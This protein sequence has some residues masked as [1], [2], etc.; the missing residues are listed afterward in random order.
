MNTFAVGWIMMSS[1]ILFLNSSP[2]IAQK[3]EVRPDSGG[4][5]VSWQDLR[6]QL[7]H[8]N[9]TAETEV[10]LNS[11]YA[12]REFSCDSAAT[13]K[14][15]FLAAAPD[16]AGF[17]AS[18]HNIAIHP[19]GKIRLESAGFSS[20]K[21]DGY[22][23]SDFA[24]YVAVRYAGTRRGVP[25]MEIVAQL[26]YYNTATGELALVESGTIN[27]RFGKEISDE[28]QNKIEKQF[29]A[30][31]VNPS[32]IISKIAMAYSKGKNNTL[33]PDDDWYNPAKT[34]LQI[35]TTRDGAAM[36][37]GNDIIA[38][39]PDWRGKPTAYLELL[40]KGRPYPIAA[41]DYDGVISAADTFYFAGRR[42]AGDTTF[43]D[44]VTDKEPFFLMLG[45]K[46]S[47]AR[48]QPMP[49]VTA[50]ETL[51]TVNIALH[52]EEDHDFNWGVLVGTPGSSS[53]DS[54]NFSY[55]KGF[56]WKMLLTDH[57]NNTLRANA[58][59]LPA[60]DESMSVST[61][62]YTYTTAPAEYR[63]RLAVNG[64]SLAAQQPGNYDYYRY[65]A[66]VPA[67]MF[68]PGNNSLMFINQNVKSSENP[69]LGIDYFT[70]SGKARPF[71]VRGNANF[72][73]P[74]RSASAR[75]SVPGFSAGKI[76]AIDTLTGKYTLTY[77]TAGSFLAAGAAVAGDCS[78]TANDTSTATTGTGLLIAAAYPDGSKTARFFDIKSDSAANFLN[79]LPDGAG[80]AAAYR[81]TE[82]LPAKVRE[83]F[84]KQGAK[85]DIPISWAWACI[86]RKNIAGSLKEQVS[87]TIARADNF[88]EHTGGAS[89]QAS[90][91]LPAADETPLMLADTTAIESVEL[92]LLSPSTLRSKPTDADV[93][94]VAHPNFMQAANRLAAYRRTQGYTVTTAAT[95]DIYKEFSY[96]KKTPEA[97]KSYMRFLSDNRGKPPAYLILFGDA[98]W[99]PL[100]LLP[101]SNQTDYVPTHGFPVSDFWFG[102]LTDNKQYD[103]IVGRLPVHSPEDAQGVVDKLIEYDTL[104]A[105]PWMRNFFFL[106]G[107]DGYSQQNEFYNVFDYAR[108]TL[109][110]TPVCIDTTR[111]RRNPGGGVEQL[112]AIEVRNQVNAGAAWMNFWG[113]GAPEIFDVDGWQVNTLTNRSKYNVLATFSCQ[114]GAFANPFSECRNEGY[115]IA[116]GKGSIAAF[117]N[118][119]TG[120]VDIDKFVNYNMFASVRQ[121]MRRFGDILYAA[122]GGLGF[123]PDYR[124][125]QQQL[126]LIGDPLAR[127]IF[128]SIPD[129]YILDDD[130]RIESPDGSPLVSESDSLTYI[131]A[132]VRN[133]GTHLDSVAIRLI[134]RYNGQSDTLYAS[135]YDVCSSVPA[136]FILKTENKPG[137]HDLSLEINFDNSVMEG[138]RGRNFYQTSFDVLTG[139]AQ[140][141]DPLPLWNVAASKPVFRFVRS[142]NAAPLKYECEIWNDDLTINIASDA[143]SETKGDIT[144]HEAYLEWKPSK[145]ILN[146]GS[147]YIV[148][149]RATNISTGNQS[150][151]LVIPFRAV[152]TESN[153]F[154]NIEQSLFS[155]W[156]YAAMNSALPDSSGGVSIEVKKVPMVSIARCGLNEEKYRYSRI[157]IGSMEYI[158]TP[159]MSN[160]NIVHFKPFDSIGI[161]RD[162]YGFALP[163]WPSH[164]M[165][166]CDAAVRYLRDSVAIGDVVVISVSDAGLNGFLFTEPGQDG[167][168]TSF[169]TTMH[170][171]GARLPDTVFYGKYYS[172]G[173]PIVDKERYASG[174]VMVGTKGGA[175]GSARELCGDRVDSLVL[176]D[177]LI[178]YGKKGSVISPFFGPSKK[179]IV[180]QTKLSLPDSF[181]TA[182]VRLVGR[183]RN[184]G[185]EVMLA[186]ANSTAELNLDTI[187]AHE[188]PY[189][190][191]EANLERTKITVNPVLN[192]WSIHFTPSPEFVILKN[193]S[194]FPDSVLRGDT[195]VCSFTVKNIAPRA[196]SDTATVSVATRPETGAGSAQ[197]HLLQLQPLAPDEEST[198]H[199]TFN[200]AEAGNLTG[201]YLVVDP[202]SR[203]DELYRFNNKRRVALR[204]GEDKV[205][206]SAEVFADGIR[207]MNGDVVAPETHF[208]IVINDN[209]RLPID[210]ANIRVRLNRFLQ[211][212]TNTRNVSFTQIDDGSAARAR[213]SFLS[214]KTLEV[215]D[216]ILT[217]I[218]QDATANR[219]TLRLTLNVVRNGSIE[220]ISAAPNPIQTAG[221]IRYRYK[222]QMQDA[223]VSIKI[224]N[225]QGK[226]IKI[227]NGS[228]RI[229]LN[230]IAW[231]GR[232]AN[233]DDVPPGLYVFLLNITTDS[234]I[235]PQT[236]RLILIR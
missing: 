223:P 48:L 166:N 149:I 146:S 99:D 100:R 96:G 227:L 191:F 50:S 137:R 178:L 16:T 174:Y 219:D 2:L 198:F 56:I 84:A 90:I 87:K 222:G 214:R 49:D 159:Y 136:E 68:F 206:P 151:W 88:Y 110:D 170:S 61:K 210:S 228:A 76:V 82:P 31:I 113:H 114:T 66:E 184:T 117:G 80:I 155:D 215:G 47:A 73:V 207:V 70:L 200:T 30:D 202:E 125:A 22:K 86:L 199:T 153:K 59:F 26:F 187:S 5:I 28:R 104:S 144:F 234:Y 145:L 74:S 57:Y 81:A 54:E 217:I 152:A 230:E 42:A 213:L 130:V 150:S 129:L 98:S 201:I 116:A 3:F 106:S 120:T 24:P 6:C 64:D 13:D 35:F 39:Q 192:S 186:E 226:Q 118:T 19:L 193:A 93:I 203:A 72:S 83:F 44:Y 185:E 183:R 53:Y 142:E 154:V 108:E 32:Q 107:G 147:D 189:I 69:T 195:S 9:N 140:P 175:P 20:S 10:A 15:R 33:A 181:A 171:F 197:E 211:P 45:D 67:A 89:Y 209:S 1:L 62:Y 161:Y 162:Y 126:S 79:G 14:L 157:I 165:G 139:G 46:P 43:Y 194:V 133:V 21:A 38:A 51:N 236:G 204:V 63:V 34:Y 233:G 92:A 36:F 160:F 158:E 40:H 65:T 109:L 11:R 131:R 75:L 17:S 168:A 37:T 182:N 121:G 180:A 141:L 12:Y 55:G 176:A 225:M 232:D 105:R 85:S 78:A 119:G 167:D 188:F 132:L 27:I 235:E 95:D 229:G 138:R 122:K 224:F 177:T 115:V 221:S 190:R 208:D 77:G 231:D 7:Y 196:N 127:F 123:N 29:F 52:I 172:N 173:K 220:D 124:V 103:I 128:D 58:T 163:S 179:W 205:P 102:T 134:H 91:A 101:R 156:K 143:A 18:L 4:F 23:G 164:R 41:L 135:I 111:M 71:A 218:S 97:I 60:A 212:D 8:E 216:N 94:I 169:L 112:L 148:K 25:L